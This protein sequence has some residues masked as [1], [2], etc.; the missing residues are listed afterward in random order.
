MKINKLWRYL[1]FCFILSQLISCNQA[2]TPDD[3]NNIASDII[4]GLIAHYQFTG[5]LMDGSGNGHNGIAHSTTYAIDRFGNNNQALSLKGSLT[6]YMEVPHHADLN[7]S[8]SFTISFWINTPQ[9]PDYGVVLGKGQDI[10][11]F[12]GFIIDDQAHNFLLSNSSNNNQPCAS[13]NNIVTNTWHFITCIQDQE[14]NKHGMYIDNKFV[15][16]IAYFNFQTTNFYPLIIGR[17]FVNIDGS[18]GYE[19]PFRG[20]FD[21]LRIYNRA[22]TNLEI[23]TL[24]EETQ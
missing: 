24:S 9:L 15:A 14:G 12:Y 1:V 5:S 21:D 7:L 4:T 17:L 20:S 22:L 23:K 16:E 13:A 6:S 2:T 19:Y 8:G 10:N 18:G 3:N 11:N